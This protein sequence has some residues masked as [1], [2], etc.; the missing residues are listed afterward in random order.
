[1][2]FAGAFKKNDIDLLSKLARKLESKKEIPI[3]QPDTSYRVSSVVKMCP[4]E[5]VLRHIHN[6]KK[7]QT[8]DARLQRI[9]DFGTA[10]HEFVQNN[11]FSD[12][13]IG[14]WQCVSCGAIWQGKRPASCGNSC[15][16]TDFRYK[17]IKMHLDTHNL[18]G[19]TDGVLDIDGKHVLLEIKTCSSKQYE[20]IVN[21]RKSP[22]QAHIDQ[23]QLYMWL[24]GVERAVVIYL[25]KDESLIAQFVV[26]KDDMVAEA[27]IKRVT[28]ARDGMI[29]KVVPDRE[30]CDS[31][32][33][34]RAKACSTRALCFA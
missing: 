27:F 5:E 7:F 10:V 18:S 25:E 9:F 2:S 26:E 20:V 1:M 11:W 29:N 24:L 34:S 3:P 23:V 12:W 33:C 22:L 16:S 13:L 28:Q 17:E 21:M 4:R 31:A 15:V 14:E 19:H 8:I 6:V 32:T 30:L